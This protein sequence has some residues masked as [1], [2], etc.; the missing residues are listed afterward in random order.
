M[1][2]LFFFILFPQVIISHYEYVLGVPLDDRKAI[3]NYTINSTKE[4]PTDPY[5]GDSIPA[6]L[7]EEETAASASLITMLWSL[8]V[9]SFAV[10]G[11]IAS[12]C[13]GWLG[14]RLGRYASFINK[15]KHGK[16]SI[17]GF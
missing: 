12:F 5:L 17:W 7:V 13:G 3:N 16:F 4:L 8:S 6:S 14:D 1:L 11:M 15:Y 9:S 2:E 10:G